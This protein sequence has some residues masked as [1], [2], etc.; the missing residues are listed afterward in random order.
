[1]KSYTDAYKALNIEQKRA[2]DT[3]EGPVMVIAGPGTGK[4]Q[5]LA[6]R[7]AHIRQQ[8]DTPADGILCLTFTNAGVKAMR[9]RLMHYMGPEATKVKISTFHSF[10]MSVIEEFF[11]SL[12]LESAPALLDTTATVVLYDELL[13]AKQWQYL[14]PRSNSTMFVHDIQSTISLL[15]RDRI[16][17]D[18]FRQLIIE[19]IERIT[20]DPEHVS[21]RGETK[22]QLKKEAEKKIES[23]ERTREM[24]EFYQAYELLKKARNVVDYNDV[25]ELLVQLV[26][27]SEEVRATLRERF[28]YVLVDEHQDSSGIQNEFLALVW[29]DIEQPNLFVVG[30]D[31]QLIYGFGGASLSHFEQFLQT[32]TP[33]TRITLTQN[34]R[35]SQTILDAAEQLLQS[36]LA[37]GKLR[38]NDTTAHPVMLVESDYARDE[39]IAAGLDIKKKIAQGPSERQGRAGVSV[40]ECALLVPKNRQVKNA[41]QVLQD[42]GLPVAASTSLRLFELADTQAFLTVLRSLVDP[43]DTI[44][45]SRSILDPL[46]GIPPLIGHTFLAAID[47]RT[48]S[49]HTL[50]QSKE[51]QIAAWGNKLNEW[52]TIAQTADAYAMV[53]IVAETCLLATAFNDEVLRRRV[54][55]IRTLLHMALAQAERG[56]SGQAG[57]KISLTDYLA[58]IDRLQ[59]YDEDI[60]LAVFAADKGIKVLTLHGSKGLE[61]DAVWIA[62]MDERSFNSTKRQSFTMPAS[63][64]K[65]LEAEDEMVKK[66]ELYVAITR[67]KRFCMI[68]FSRHSYTGSDQQLAHVVAAL[69]ESIIVRQSAALTEESIVQADQKIFVTA[70]KIPSLYDVSELV[71]QEYQSHNVSVTLLNNFF[72]CPR[73]WY[74]RNI[75][76]LPEP[77]NNALHVGNIVHKTIEYVLKAA[78]APTAEAVE[79][80]VISVAALEARYDER[81]VA[82]LT[83]EA[84]PIIMKWME[85][86]VPAIAQPFSTERALTYREVAFP[87]LTFFG[88]IDLVEEVIS[89]ETRVTDWKTGTVKTATDIEKRDEENRMSGLLRQLVMYSFLINGVSNGDTDVSQSRLVFLEAKK[90]DKHAVYTRHV[91]TQDIAALRQDITDYMTLI[92]NGQW[93]ARPCN[94]KTYGEHDTCEYCAMA[95]RFGIT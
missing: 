76:Q 17:P 4:T 46:S 77:Q 63:L 91:S 62:H 13:H 83:G 49:L 74:F 40:D 88:K 78:T 35:S 33:V 75:L 55:I 5:V 58:F 23:L 70:Q 53:Q 31:R 85:Q 16:N 95:H 20:H 30:D 66:R 67:A 34:Y 18:T 3:I 93:L 60:A 29:K 37:E 41:I 50:L 45:I 47:L 12:G 7:I 54:E 69:P 86:Y 94:A 43:F 61:F 90:A 24:A 19:D 89:N 73:K 44:H 28:L 64:E 8:T 1:M 39:I 68:S 82:E 26:E 36:T 84:V 15:K 57:T 48:L 11:M 56:S 71:R 81:L 59:S 65:S 25:L 79:Q 87:G 92:E 10:A 32:F 2:V 27:T 42:M 72:E 80:K 38:G 52:M 6:L 14:R 22:G 9:E 21:S 51:S